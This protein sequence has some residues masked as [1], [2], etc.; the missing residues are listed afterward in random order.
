MAGC[1]I[2]ALLVI[3]VLSI[4]MAAVICVVGR[5][6]AEGRKS[7]QV[8]LPAIFFGFVT[9]FF[10]WDRRV[11]LGRGLPTVG[12]AWRVTCAVG[13]VGPC[14]RSGVKMLVPGE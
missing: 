7:I 13:V 5:G 8:L 4:D 3:C 2:L 9:G 11:R 10:G 12:G 6:G 14:A 1:G